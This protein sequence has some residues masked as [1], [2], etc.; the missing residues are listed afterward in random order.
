MA[1]TWA[2]PGLLIA[3]K[4]SQSDRFSYAAAAMKKVHY[5]PFYYENMLH[6]LPGKLHYWKRLSDLNVRN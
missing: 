6:E 1:P 2:G 5:L 4:V 3:I